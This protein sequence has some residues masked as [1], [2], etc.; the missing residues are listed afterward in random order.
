MLVS[1][2]LRVASMAGL[3][4]KLRTKAATQMEESEVV[5]IQTSLSVKLAA[6]RAHE[7][8]IRESEESSLVNEERGWGDAEYDSSRQT[9]RIGPVDT[10]VMRSYE[11]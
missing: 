11:F 6:L 10:I 7:A 8:A 2:A 9:D 3:I 5:D 1:K 4:S